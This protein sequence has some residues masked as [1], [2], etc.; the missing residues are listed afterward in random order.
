MIL[1]CGLC[2]RKTDKLIKVVDKIPIYECPS[3]RLGFIDQKKTKKTNL[4]RL[5]SFDEYKKVEK[6]ITRRLDE[7]TDTIVKYKKKGIVLE[8]GPGFGLLSSFL[9]QKGRYHLEVVEPMLIP[10]YLSKKVYKMHK[11]TLE[12]FLK[13]RKKKYDLIII[14][15]VLEHLKNPFQSLAKLSFLLNKGGILV[16]QTPNYQSLMQEVTHKWSW[17]M[18]EDHKWFFSP[19]SLDKA[20]AKSGF[21]EV[22]KQTY[23]DW[24]DFKKNLDGNFSRFRFK[25]TRRFAKLLFFVPFFPFY[26]LTRHLFWKAGGGG[27]IFSISRKI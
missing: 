4:R 9:L 17:W 20:L 1:K 14:F 11:I 24:I 26:F 12:S 21:D 10:Q 6:G 22:H 19:H 5:Y 18:V 7:L 8:V 13:R 23:E 3:C 25:I 27:L 2:G 15:D 16:I